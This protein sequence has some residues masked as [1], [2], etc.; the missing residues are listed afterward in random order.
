MSESSTALHPFSADDLRQINQLQLITAQC[1][2]ISGRLSKLA[3]LKDQ[4]E[5]LGKDPNREINLM[6]NRYAELAKQLRSEVKDHAHYFTDVNRI[7][8]RLTA[9]VINIGDLLWPWSILQLPT[10]AEGINQTPTS[11]DTSGEIA[12]SGLFQGTG[13][14][15]GMPDNGGTQEQWWVHNWTCTAVLPPAPQ[16]GTV[17]YRFGANCEAI[18]YHVEGTGSLTSFITVGTT[19]D[20]GMPI[21]NWQTVGWPFQVTLPQ[22]GQAAFGGGASVV[23][24]INV[25]AGRAAAV[26]IIIGVIVSVIDGYVMFLPDS[27]FG[28]GLLGQSG[29]AAYGKIQYR[30]NPLW[31]IE[32]VKEA[33]H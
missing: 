30:F 5:T 21:T 12:T 24:D 18:V 32:G 15:G 10:M 26:T 23:G 29:Y 11:P 4:L 1:S 3:E 19:S 31:V 7:N 6:R 8:D 13:A 2:Q 9:T 27:T 22:P 28:I 25:N 16:Q 20:T 33:I 17:S 14:W